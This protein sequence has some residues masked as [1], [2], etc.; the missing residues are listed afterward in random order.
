MARTNPTSVKTVL[1]SDLDDPIVDSYIQVAN[2]LVTEKLGSSDLGATR[3]EMIERW[4]SAHL[5]AITR[6]RFAIRETIGEASVQYAGEFGRG[7]D[8]TSYG[9]MVMILDTTGELSKMS[10]K[11]VRIIAIDSFSS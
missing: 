1:G 4:L 3:L 10:K 9:Q 8:S 5:I 11:A 2:A 7:L 6:E